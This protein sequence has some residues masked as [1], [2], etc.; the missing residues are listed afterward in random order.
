MTI[1][2]IYSIDNAIS[3]KSYIG[4]SVHIIGR[5]GYHKRLLRKNQHDN[6][7]LQNA[8]NKYGSDCFSFK[9]LE[10]LPKENLLYVEQ[11]YLDFCRLIPHWFYNMAYDASAP[12]RGKVPWNKGKKVF[13]Q[14]QI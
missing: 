10:E 9:V 5:W 6:K 4:S 13:K 11:Q 7:H 8:W 1:C 2:G 14:G 3:K 12:M